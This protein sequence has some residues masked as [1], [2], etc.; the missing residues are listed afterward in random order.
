[1]ITSI[2]DASEDQVN[3]GILKSVIPGHRS[4]IM[5]TKKLTPE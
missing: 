5:V 1:M 2:A 4:L 3:T